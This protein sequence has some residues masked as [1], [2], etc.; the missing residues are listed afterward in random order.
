MKGV[1]GQL[2]IYVTI[3]FLAGWIVYLL[4][5]ISQKG[6]ETNLLL[7]WEDVEQLDTCLWVDARVGEAFEAAHYQGAILVNEEN[8]ETGFSDLVMAWLPD[9]AI[10]VYCSSEA[11]LRSHHV[12]ARLREELGFENVFV[13]EGGWDVLQN[14]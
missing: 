3:G 7:N 2:L 1:L 12:A 5:P 13:L 11:C 10:V 6:L 9:Q 4:N 8:W 14:K